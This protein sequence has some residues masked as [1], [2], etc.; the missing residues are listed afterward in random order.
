MESSEGGVLLADVRPGGPADLAGIRG[1]DRIVS[2]AG[3]KIENLY[4]MTFALQ[5]HKPG[6]TIDVVVVR[7]EQ[8]VTLKATLGT[9][10]AAAPTTPHGALEIKAG[11]PFEKKF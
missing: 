11:K 3:T 7:N 1:K 2:M 9:R 4:D 6:E 5:D 10:G 8:H